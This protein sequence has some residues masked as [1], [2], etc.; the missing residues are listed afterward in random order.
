M[1]ALKRSFLAAAIS[2]ISLWSVAG[3]IGVGIPFGL[4][5][6]PEVGVRLHF[7]DLYALNAFVSFSAAGSQSDF[8]VN[9]DNIFYIAE[10]GN[11]KQYLA[12]NIS[13]DFDRLLGTAGLY[14]LQYRFNDYLDVYGQLGLGLLFQEGADTQV[15]TTRSGLGVIFYLVRE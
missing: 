8:V 4:Q 3:A 14:G 2:V 10:E 12:A 15:S 5:G 11:L 9:L 6:G 1:T 13:S 7:T